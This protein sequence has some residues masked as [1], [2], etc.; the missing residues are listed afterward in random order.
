MV[1]PCCFD[2]NE[3]VLRYPCV[4]MILQHIQ[5]VVRVL[6]LSERVFVYNVGIICVLKDAWGNPG[7]NGD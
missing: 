6:H 2:C 3:I 1:Q 7:L 5:G 4:P